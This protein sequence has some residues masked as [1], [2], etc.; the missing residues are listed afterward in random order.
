[1]GL[2]FCPFFVL[3]IWHFETC[4]DG[5]EDKRKSFYESAAGIAGRR[6]DWLGLIDAFGWLFLIFRQDVTW[7]SLFRFMDRGIAR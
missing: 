3:I 5:F 2:F 4:F 1:M 6:L 7:K